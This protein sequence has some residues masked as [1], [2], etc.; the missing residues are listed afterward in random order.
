M[1]DKF[2][3]MLWNTRVFDLLFHG[4]NGVQHP[5]H[6]PISST[7]QNT[8]TARGQQS[9]QLQGFGRSSLGQVKHLTPHTHRYKQSEYKTPMNKLKTL[10]IR[11]NA[12]LLSGLLKKKINQH[13]LFNQHLTHG[14][15]DTCTGLSSVRNSP[16]SSSPMLFPLRV[17]A[18]TS[19]GLHPFPHTAAS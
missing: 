5:A 4:I 1:T 11:M 2:V 3:M 18:S 14:N 12:S 6:C 17:L 16:S 8:H 9:A 19:R 15:W 13:L 10:L 7:H